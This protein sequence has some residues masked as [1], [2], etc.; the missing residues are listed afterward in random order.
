MND[1]DSARQAMNPAMPM[2]ETGDSVQLLV[3]DRG[4]GFV[5]EK[6]MRGRGIGL[7]SMQER[8]KLAGGTLSIESHLGRGTIVHA[9][10]PLSV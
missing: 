8:M 7:V 4:K 3:S 5:V 2:R 1:V 6:A 10:V 9:H